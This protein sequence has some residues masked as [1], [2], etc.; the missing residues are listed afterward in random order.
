ME[1]AAAVLSKRSQKE[2][3]QTLHL[4][5]CNPQLLLL[6][7]FPFS[8]PDI[9]FDLPNLMLLVILEEIPGHK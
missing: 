1:V 4:L 7:L 3:D 5:L 8:L 6:G 2:A 9:S